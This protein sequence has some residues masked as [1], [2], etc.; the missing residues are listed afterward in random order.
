[1][2]QKAPILTGRLRLKD[3]TQGTL[4]RMSSR[5]TGAFRGIARVAAGVLTRDLVRGLFRATQEGMR[6]AATAGTLQNAFNRLTLAAG[7]EDM[8]LEKLRSAVQG[9]VGDIGLLTAANNAMALGLPVNR[10]NDLFRAARVVGNAMGRTTL[11]AV[12]DLTTGIGR[13]SRLILDNL[14]I[15]VDTNAAHEAYAQSLGKTVSEMTEVERKAAFMGAAIEALERKAIIL[16]GTT[17]DTQTAFERWGASLENLKR[18][19]GE[20]FLPIAIEVTS[21]ITNILDTLKAAITE[22]KEG[23]WPGAFQVIADAA[24]SKLDDLVL[25]FDNIDWEGIWTGI[26]DWW[27]SIDWDLLFENLDIFMGNLWSWMKTAAE[28][29]GTISSAFLAWFSEIEWETVFGNLD[30]FMADFFLF[31]FDAAGDI[32]DAF[33][34]WFQ[35]VDWSAVYQSAVDAFQAMVESD[36]AQFLLETIE[37]VFPRIKIPLWLDW[38]LNLGAGV[39]A[40]GGDT[41]ATGLGAGG[42]G[43]G[44]R[45]TAGIPG[46]SSSPITFIFN[47]ENLIGS[48]E[49]A[50]QL[51]EKAAE[52]AL[53]KLSRSGK[54]P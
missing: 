8:T 23:D 25:A 35:S 11:E 19:L 40:L 1:M 27:A 2:S 43:G 34:K 49:A 48:D 26:Q 54:L 17:S 9:T 28:A 47:V 39:G 6:L 53:N 3:E 31:M 21:G 45:R 10:L 12:N 14:G 38:L 18:R 5:I 36:M 20:T 29:A 30:D 52:Y 7:V 22:I 50:R 24:S 44:G 13:Q 16:E 37:G 33:I 51:G 41:G 46:V 32:G 4:K 15:L 42:G